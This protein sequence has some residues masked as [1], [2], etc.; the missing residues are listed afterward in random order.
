ME[1]IARLGPGNALADVK[2]VSDTKIV[3]IADSA[4]IRQYIPTGRAR[5]DSSRRSSSGWLW[6]VCSWESPYS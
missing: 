1:H 6:T 2:D 4:A 5:E 3:K